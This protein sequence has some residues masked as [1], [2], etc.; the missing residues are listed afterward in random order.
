MK[1]L[2][3]WKWKMMK[4][5]LNVRYSKKFNKDRKLIIKRG[6]NIQKLK[7]VVA[8]LQECKPLPLKY[9]DHS[10]SGNYA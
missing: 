3:I 4:M 2:G 5:L 7:D 10:L 1:C 6:Y 8:L 9:L